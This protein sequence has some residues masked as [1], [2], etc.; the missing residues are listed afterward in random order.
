MSK[1]YKQNRKCNHNVVKQCLTMRNFE[2]FVM[3]TY[4]NVVELI[5]KAGALRMHLKQKRPERSE[6]Y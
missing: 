5:Q 4:Q 6:K 3:R 2:D 1:S